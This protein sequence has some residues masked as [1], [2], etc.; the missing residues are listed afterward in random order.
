MCPCHAW[1]RHQMETSFASLALCVG[2]SPAIG[3]FPDK[4]QWR[5]TLMFSLI[6]T[7]INGWENNREAGDWRRH[8]AHYGV[9]VMEPFN[10]TF[11]GPQWQWPAQWH[12]LWLCPRQTRTSTHSGNTGPR[13]SA[14]DPRRHWHRVAPCYTPFCLA[15]SHGGGGIYRWY[16]NP[17]RYAVKNRDSW[18]LWH[19]WCNRGSSLWQLTLP[20]VT[21][22]LV[23]WRHSVLGG[24]RVVKS[25]RIVAS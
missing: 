7:W 8:C 13:T 22:K 21:I 1:W 11:P 3:E 16:A 23:L 12:G 2:N 24:Y 18:Q 15:A 4:G 5:G 9:I 10:F 19:H 6:C 14:R 25:R 17:W 20:L